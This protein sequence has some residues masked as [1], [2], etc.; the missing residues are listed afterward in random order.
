MGLMLFL[1]VSTTMI[2]ETCSVLTQS[3]EGKVFCMLS[4]GDEEALGRP[5]HSNRNPIDDI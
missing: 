3:S 2:R 5:P 1:V 4:R